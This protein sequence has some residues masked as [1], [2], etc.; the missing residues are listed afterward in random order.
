MLEEEGSATPHPSLC[1]ILARNSQWDIQR[2]NF[3]SPCTEVCVR[4]QP[5]QEGVGA[6]LPLVSGKIFGLLRQP[7][8]ET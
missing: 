2:S 6:Y 3:F 1:L 8:A 7:P 4:K 5:Q